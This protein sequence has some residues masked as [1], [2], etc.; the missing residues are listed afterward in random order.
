MKTFRKA[1]A[2]LLLIIL[3]VMPLAG[4]SES[5]T[6]PDSELETEAEAEEASAFETLRT[7]MEEP[8]SA[9]IPVIRGEAFQAE[10][11]EKTPDGILCQILFENKI[12]Q[13]KKEIKDEN[14]NP[15]QDFKII[16]SAI[17]SE[18]KY[19]AVRYAN[20]SMEQMLYYAYVIGSNYNMLQ[21][22][23]PH[24]ETFS[25]VVKFGDKILLINDAENAAEFT[26]T[27]IEAVAGL[28]GE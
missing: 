20:L 9:D 26:N 4:L 25:I 23:L 24:G 2:M 21:G 6:E 13:R 11:S 3:A 18:R 22:M 27:I 19:E 12:D 10:L 8:L 28:A 5:E 14:G 17:N 7:L 1:L 15:I 16:N